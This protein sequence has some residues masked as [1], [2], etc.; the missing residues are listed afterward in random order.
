MDH[1]GVSKHDK[2]KYCQV[3]S[4]EF[5]FVQKLNSMARQAAAERAWSAISRFYEHCKQ[6]IP[7]K[8][9]YPQFKKKTRSVEYKTRLLEA[10]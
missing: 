5:P 7:G 6:K 8:K 1:R 4:R 10:C 3:L 9:G 2:R